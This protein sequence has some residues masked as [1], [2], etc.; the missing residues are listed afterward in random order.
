VR[1]HKVEEE[2]EWRRPLLE[3][4]HRGGLVAWPDPGQHLVV[5]RLNRPARAVDNTTVDE[6]PDLSWHPLG[7]LL[8]ERGLVR[9]E[10]VQLALEIQEQ[11]GQ[12]LGEILLS[13]NL[14]APSDVARALGDQHE[15]RIRQLRW[16]RDHSL[17]TPPD[18]KH[19][20]AGAD[21]SYR[22]LGQVLLDRGLVTEDGLMRALREQKHNGKLLGE[23][24]VGRRWLTAE[25]IERAL[26]EQH[27]LEAGDD[28]SASPIY[29]VR[30][31]GVSESIATCPDFLEATDAAFDVLDSREPEELVIVKIDTAGEERVWVYS[32]GATAGEAA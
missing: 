14:I 32:R 3:L 2:P 7:E 17:E 13:R 9:P 11:T 4:R 15:I 1:E 24:L 31:A 12:L 20:P 8:V 30:E 25:D 21:A 19:P 29:E 26:A 27:G 16:E 18:P 5:V 23:I 6:S 28:V 22:P 10:D